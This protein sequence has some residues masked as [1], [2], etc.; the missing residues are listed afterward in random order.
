MSE[1]EIKAEIAALQ[2]K[3]EC[4]MDRSSKCAL[5]G[6]WEAAQ[7]IMDDAHEN[8]V[9]RISELEV[10]LKKVEGQR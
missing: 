9:G 1:Q 4:E 8:I 2:A 6:H 7:R 5:L 3:L 10:V